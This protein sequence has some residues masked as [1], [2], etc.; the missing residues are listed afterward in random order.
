MRSFGKAHCVKI[1]ESASEHLERFGGHKAAAGMQLD[2]SKIENFQA[3]LIN[4]MKELYPQDTA[5]APQ[6]FYDLEITHNTSLS[7]DEVQKLLSLEPFGAGNPEP[8]FLL[9]NVP[10]STFDLLKEVHIKAKRYLG[11][12][13]IGFNHANT[14]KKIMSKG[15]SN[16]DLL[17]CPE[18]NSFRN[19]IT[20]Q[21]RIQHLRETSA[22]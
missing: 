17:V 16:V 20:V 2:S 10:C 12:D 11:H 8:L 4:A 5:Q 9:R 15:S 13:M 19:Q 3:T 18:I 7:V 21:L 22:S 14:L 1:L 6:V